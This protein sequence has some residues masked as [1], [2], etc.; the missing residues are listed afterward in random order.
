MIIDA[1]SARLEKEL[2]ELRGQQSNVFTVYGPWVP[3]VLK[4]IDIAHKKGMFSA[5]PVGPLGR[6]M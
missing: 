2:T 4:Q 5:K 3:E 6:L 1:F